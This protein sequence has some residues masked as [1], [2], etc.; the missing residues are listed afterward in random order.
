MEYYTSS[1]FRYNLVD[2]RDVEEAIE[3]GSALARISVIERVNSTEGIIET[4]RKFAKVI[5]DKGERKEFA[6]EVKYLLSDKLTTE[7]IE[8][9][10]DMLI[11][12]E[13][14]DGMLH[15]Q[16]VIRRDFENARKKAIEEGMKEGRQE[17]M[18]EGRQ[19]GMKEGRQKGMKEGRQE[20]MKEGMKKGRQKGMLDVAKKMLAENF[21]IDL[22]S[23]LTGLKKEQFIK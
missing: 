7:E 14:D 15:A 13:G 10:E 3:I 22:I 4:I 18:K 16:M 12:K 8:K 17:G 11:E 6:E 5:K 20:G 19:E 2:I 23:K 1:I 21:D 9:I